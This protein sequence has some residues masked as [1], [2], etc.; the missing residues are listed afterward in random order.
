[1]GFPN[2]R[3]G[4]SPWGTSVTANDLTVRGDMIFANAT[5][6]SSIQ[7]N[8]AKV[9]GL[10]A[11]HGS[12][13]SGPIL[14]RRTRVDGDAFFIENF[15]CQGL[16]L[17]QTEFGADLRV[18]ETNIASTGEPSLD[19]RHSQ[20][21]GD[22]L[23][24]PDIACSGPL[25]MREAVVGGSVHIDS[26]D[27]GCEGDKSLD[28]TR[29]GVAN[30]FTIGD[31]SFAGVLAMSGARVGWRLSIVGSEISGTLSDAGVQSGSSFVG[32]GLSATELILT[33]VTTVGAIVL[34]GAKLAGST[35]VSDLAVSGANIEGT[36]L[37]L[38]RITSAGSVHLRSSQ[39]AGSIRT[40]S[41]D[42][43]GQ[44]L[45]SKVDIHGR[46]HDGD[47]L[48]LS[49]SVLANGVNIQDE[50]AL[51]GRADA[52]GARGSGQWLVRFSKIV[53]SDDVSPAEL[54]VSNA[55]IDGIALFACPG[56]VDLTHTTIVQSLYLPDAATTVTLDAAQLGTLNLPPAEGDLPPSGE[57]WACR[58]VTTRARSS[59]GRWPAGGLTA[60]ST[61]TGVDRDGSGLRSQRSA[62]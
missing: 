43:H 45:M 24:G 47:S 31:S 40:I 30:D 5:V 1:M 48:L 49:R 54:D 19:I 50:C 22:L 11:F 61:P 51:A 8:S 16:H 44:L 33:R 36:S 15:S 59:T 62:K 23:F 20:I 29:L 17:A 57:P 3:I 25:V 7:I 41:A 56:H 52:S 42:I 27:I 37:H 38:D 9:S 2:A 55:M 46:D 39:F 53:A 12:Q 14:M 18:S 13:V 10:L 58:S 28:A 26:A 60:R 32:D 21:K 34:T 6:A 4:T 35:E